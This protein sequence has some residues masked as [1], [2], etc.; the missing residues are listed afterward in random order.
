MTCNKCIVV[1]FIRLWKTGYAAVLPER[2][3][4]ITPP[5]Y[6]FM[7]ITLMPDI[8]NNAIL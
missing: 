2:I 4:L 6:D 8:K 5:G 3:K 1:A 7:H